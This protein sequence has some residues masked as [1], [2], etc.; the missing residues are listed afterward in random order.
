MEYEQIRALRLAYPF[1]PF[2]FV[3]DDGRRVPVDQPYYLA[4]SPTKRFITVSLSGDDYEVVRLE[5]IRAV[6]VQ[7][8]PPAPGA[9]GNGA[10][11]A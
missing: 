10:G 11:G 5:R 8:L 6:D 1:R 4:M 9:T 2:N 7:E 3:L